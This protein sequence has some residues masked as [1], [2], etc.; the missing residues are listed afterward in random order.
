MTMSQLNLKNSFRSLERQGCICN[1]KKGFVDDLQ[2]E[3]LNLEKVKWETLKSQV[4]N[5]V[6]ISNTFIYQLIYSG[7]TK[8]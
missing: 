3:S 2:F 8:H 4:I 7:R 5:S 1:T 6:S